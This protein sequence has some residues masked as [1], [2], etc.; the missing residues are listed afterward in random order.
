MQDANFDAGRERQPLTVRCALY[1]YLLAAGPYCRF[2]PARQTLVKLL[3]GLG[4]AEAIC[5]R[6]NELGRQWG[7]NF[8]HA[9]HS[10]PV[11][12]AFAVCPGGSTT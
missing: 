9:L 3:A 5:H 1:P 8:F 6:I 4:R 11:P 7:I 2:Q 12:I 10:L